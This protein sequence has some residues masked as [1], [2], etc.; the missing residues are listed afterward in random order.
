MA[1]A[2]G[3]TKNARH[4]ER[5]TYYHRDEGTLCTPHYESRHTSPIC[6]SAVCPSAVCASAVCASAVCVLC[7]LRVLNAREASGSASQVFLRN[8]GK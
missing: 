4:R 7:V 3:V 6:S 2:I 8:E 5:T 1:L